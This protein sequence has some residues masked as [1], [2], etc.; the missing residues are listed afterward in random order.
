MDFRLNRRT[1]AKASKRQRLRRSLRVEQLTARRVLAAITGAVFEDVD[2]SYR[3]ESSEQSLAQRLVYLDVNQNAAIDT[4][5]PF[6]ITGESGEFSFGGL[7][8]GQYQVRLYDG[9]TTQTQVTPVAA[10]RSGALLVP[11]VSSFATDNDV[12]G[13]ITNGAVTLGNYADGSLETFVVP[14]AP[15]VIGKLPD[16][17]F[18]LIGGSGGSQ[19]AWLANPVDDTVTPIDLASDGSTGGWADLA[20]DANGQGLLLREDPS[21]ELGSSLVYSIDASNQNDEILVTD[22]DLRFPSDVQ[23]VASQTGNRSIV[24]WAG[25]WTDASGEQSGLQVSLWSNASGTAISDVPVNLADTAEILDYDDQSG[26]LA[27]RNTE[28][29]VSVFDANAD[30]AL[31][32]T[33][34][35]VAGPVA[36]DGSRSL[37]A[38]VSSDDSLLEL[39]DARDGRLVASMDINTDEIGDVVAIGLEESA[40]LDLL[41]AK[42]ISR[43][44]LVKPAA[45]VVTLVGGTDSQP[46]GFGVVMQGENSPPEIPA[47]I[48]YSTNE[49]EVLVVPSPVGALSSVSDAE[50]DQ[51]V[52]LQMGPAGSGTAI[53]TVAG[54]IHYTPNLDF[55]GVDSLPIVIHDGV[56]PTEVLPVQFDVA[57]VNDAPVITL[58]LDVIAENLQPETVLGPVSIFDPDEGDVNELEITDDRFEVIDGQLVY[59]GAGVINYESEPV[60]QIEIYD[61]EYLTSATFTIEVQDENDPIE[62]IDPDFVDIVENS[63]GVFVATID[64]FDEDEGDGIMLTVDDD[65]FMIDGFDL[66]LAPGVSLD[67]EAGEVFTI[68]IT[69][70]STG[71][72]SLTEPT[73]VTVF[74]QVERARSIALSNETVLE[75]SPGEVVGD[76]IVDGYQVGDGYT[77]TVDDSRFEIVDGVLKLIDGQSVDRNDQ[78]EIELTIDVQDVGE[79]FDSVSETFLI[80]VIENSTPFHNDSFPFDVD[81]SG[82]VTPLDALLII[83]Y[84]SENGAGEIGAFVPEFV[85]VNGDGLVTPLDILLVLNA[86]DAIRNENIGTVG[87]EEPSGELPAESLP[88]EESPAEDLITQSDEIASDP[89]AQT[90]TPHEDAPVASAP[91]E[92]SQLRFQQA[93]QYRIADSLTPEGLESLALDRADASEQYADGVDASL[94]SLLDELS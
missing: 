48:A 71:G 74:D 67:Y 63:P 49:D 46:I 66:Y 45:H 51:L 9:S 73:E 70:T 60:I 22:L 18:L 92:K 5:E 19:A 23:L 41:G 13:L 27:L 12:V 20:I 26:L 54:D 55:N 75:F 78:E 81:G 61:T 59:T 76:V 16:G 29:G 58:S 65:R 86:L 28:G 85:D 1:K 38:T 80:E 30:F 6:A 53:V 79:A 72:D 84:I 47:P 87:G 82:E 32:S 44:S 39:I 34:A 77:A 37:L 17:N 35:D 43:I 7:P 21:D 42:G 83:N 14:E 57:P 36:I 56:A 40:S 25:Q 88:S 93:S 89:S 91:A 24:A 2:V 64:V 52:V 68:N 90:E 3:Q 69:A 50:E 33:V 31:L 15:S 10:T 8:D 4:G 11:E 62:Y 94:D